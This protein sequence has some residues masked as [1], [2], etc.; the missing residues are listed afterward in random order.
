MSEPV[1]PTSTA[2]WTELKRLHGDLKPDLRTWFADNPRRA[3]GFSYTAGDLFVDLSKNLITTDVVAA[4]VALAEEVGLA[5]RRDAMFAGEHINVTEDR[6]VLHT[7]LRAPRDASLIVDGVDVIPQVH[8]VLDK[9]YA[10]A[11]KVRE[12]G[13]GRRHREVDQDRGQHRHR[14]I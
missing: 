5:E 13:V 9:V 11:D 14:R 1:D 10:F 3:Q 2:A 7:A 12:R 4:L 8:E 6:A